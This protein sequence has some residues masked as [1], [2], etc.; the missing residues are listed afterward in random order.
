M[1]F[2]VNYPIRFQHCDPA[3]IVFYPRYFEMFHQIVEDWF[4]EALGVSHPDL[5]KKN[6]GIPLVHTQC[7]F[8]GASHIGDVL[9]FS[10]SVK[11][12]GQKSFTVVILGERENKKIL[13]AE[14]VI[15]FVSIE[16]ELKGIQIPENIRV[17][18]MNYVS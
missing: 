5:I 6:I 8:S 12:V 7:D 17:L 15:A 18:M 14:L 1:N 3:G 10:L 4:A 13:K 9:C 11:R 2:S 16:K